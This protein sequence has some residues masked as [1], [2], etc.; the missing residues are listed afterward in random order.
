MG[1]SINHESESG[2]ISLNDASTGVAILPNLQIVAE[3]S[4]GSSVTTAGEQKIIQN[5]K[6]NQIHWPGSK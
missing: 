6:E 3:F 2:Q 1:L 5:K 4:D